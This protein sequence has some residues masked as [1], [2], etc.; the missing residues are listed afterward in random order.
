[1]SK[2]PFAQSN[3]DSLGRWFGKNFR[4]AQ[5]PPATPEP[6]QPPASSPPP[7]SGPQPTPPISAQQPNATPIAP[8][9]V[10]T[11]ITK[12]QCKVTFDHKH[13]VIEIPNQPAINLSLTSEQQA[14]VDARLSQ[15]SFGSQG[16]HS[17]PGV[18]N[19]AIS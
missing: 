8:K 12:E 17:S 11:P 10:K 15:D 4:F 2:T 16:Q 3:A 6:L 5:V 1:M 13:I 7:M 9:P 18:A 19:P 14:S